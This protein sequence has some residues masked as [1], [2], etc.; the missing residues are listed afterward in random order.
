[1]RVL[2]FENLRRLVGRKK[3]RNEPSFERSESFKRISIRKSYLDRG[4]RRNRLQKLATDATNDGRNPRVLNEADDNSSIR[5]SHDDDDEDEDKKHSSIVYDKWTLDSNAQNSLDYESSRRMKS[6]FLV[7]TKR[8]PSVETPP[9]LVSLDKS[10]VLSRGQTDVQVFK[11]E[12]EQEEAQENRYDGSSPIHCSV[13]V[14]LGR[15]WRDI[16]M[17][18][19]V[20][21]VVETEHAIVEEPPPQRLLVSRTVSAPEKT[22]SKEEEED[23]QINGFNLSLSFSRLTTDL[24]SA[25]AAATSRNGLFRR[26]RRKR[27]AFATG[28]KPMPTVDDHFYPPKDKEILFVLP[29]KRQSSRRKGRLWREIRYLTKGPEDELKGSDSTSSNSEFDDRKLLLSGDFEKRCK[30][31]Q[32]NSSSTSLAYSSVSSTLDKA[33][34]ISD[35]NEDKIYS[36]SRSRKSANYFS[37]SQFLGYMAE[38]KARSKQSRYSSSESED[39]LLFLLVDDQ[40]NVKPKRSSVRRRSHL[41]KVN[42]KGQPVYLARKYSS[43]RRRRPCSKCS[44]CVSVNGINF[45]LESV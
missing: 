19:V 40:K 42:N 20:N 4:K 10:P 34:K 27:S 24:K 14:T 28:T 45:Q 41:R 39:E 23:P 36:K 3:D 8:K 25:A 9:V 1:M 7:S 29:E 38:A 18:E 35:F 15:V 6:N 32:T 13:S 5:K 22:V 17:P 37:S 31:S 16:A 11:E 30:A 21:H 26:G 33:P 12:E 2:S 43:R 44:F